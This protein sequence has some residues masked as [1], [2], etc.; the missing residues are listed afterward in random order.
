MC[1]VIWWNIIL[2]RSTTAVTWCGEI[3]ISP[4]ICKYCIPQLKC[5][6]KTLSMFP[7]GG[8]FYCVQY[9]AQ[10]YS[11][12]LKTITNF[13]YVHAEAK[14]DPLPRF[15][16]QEEIEMHYDKWHVRNT[17]ILWQCF[18][19]WCKNGKYIGTSTGEKDV[20]AVKMANGF[21]VHVT[22]LN[23]SE[24]QIISFLWVNSIRVLVVLPPFVPYT[25]DA[26]RMRMEV[27]KI[28]KAYTELPTFAYPHKYVQ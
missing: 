7:A 17:S 25:F 27:G 1:R 10:E 24:C 22:M 15:N 14:I 18:L 6:R 21:V 13:R 5:R 26:N 20:D 4:V 19:N 11:V 12:W 2:L 9:T 28:I 23:W 8:I 3:E 16:M